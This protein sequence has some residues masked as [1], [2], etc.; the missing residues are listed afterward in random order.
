MIR[1]LEETENG[2]C[3][4]CSR[5]NSMKLQFIYKQEISEKEFSEVKL[6]SC[7]YCGH[8]QSFFVVDGKRVVITKYY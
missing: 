7:E 4:E 1:V 3:E 5:V 6:F 8:R 2:R